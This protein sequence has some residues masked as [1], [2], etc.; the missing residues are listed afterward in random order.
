MIE[1][2]L[3]VDNA[4]AIGAMASELPKDQQKKA[5]RWGIVGAYAFRGLSL[6]L[7]AWIAGNHWLKAFGALYLIYLM[8]EHLSGKS[9]EEI[10]GGNP[11]KL[12]A[13]GLFLTIVQIEIMDL[14]LSLD[15]VVAAVA[16]DKRLWV[17]CLG[18][19]IGILALRFIA[20]YCITLIDRFPILKSTAFLLVGFVGVI[21]SVELTLELTGIHFHI[22]SLQK[23]VGII[24]ITG[25]SLL[26][27]E[28]RIGKKIFG[29]VV[30]FGQPV[31]RWLDLALG[32]I[33]WPI[34]WSLNGSWTVAKACWNRTI[35][36]W[37]N[38]SNVTT[39]S[40]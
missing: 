1:G 15:N 33:M 20:G 10:H 27:A 26:Y 34:K 3:S 18:V 7:I 2:L 8:T 16:L 29:P 37:F 17:V 40:V 13:R 36:R 4:M 35:G 39:A 9:E 11:A 19:F 21:L 31:M 6:A 28:T 5:L 30:S 22:N 38:R 23:F 25:T 24:A 14:S 12:A 32:W